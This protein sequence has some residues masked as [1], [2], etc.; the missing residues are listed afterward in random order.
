MDFEHAVYSVSEDDGSVDICAQV[1]RITAG[2]DAIEIRL[3][4]EDD[5]AKGTNYYYMRLL[6]LSP[7]QTMVSVTRL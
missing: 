6:R 7:S 2:S 3:S 1:N 4:T 5:T